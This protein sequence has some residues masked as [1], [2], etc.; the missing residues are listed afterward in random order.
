MVTTLTSFA[1]LAKVFGCKE[2]AQKI[3]AKTPY[4]AVERDCGRKAAVV[5][6]FMQDQEA[7]K[8]SGPLGT[9]HHTP[10]FISARTGMPLDTVAEALIRLM[11]AGHVRPSPN[12]TCKA[13]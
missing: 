9:I 4:L 12:G 11:V 3:I 7:C 2:K 10:D 1:E 8:Q 5:W 13:A 6:A